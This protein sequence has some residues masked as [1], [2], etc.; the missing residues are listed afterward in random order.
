MSSVCS[1]MLLYAH[2]RYAMVEGTVSAGVV[3]VRTAMLE[4]SANSVSQQP[5]Q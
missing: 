1:Q 3:N 4:L 5:I 2:R